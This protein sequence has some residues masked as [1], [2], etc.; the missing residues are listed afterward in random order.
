MR[1]KTFMT[2]RSGESAERI[3]LKHFRL[4]GVGETGC[5]DMR[6]AEN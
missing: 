6:K 2:T 3:T 4:R 1:G 5:K